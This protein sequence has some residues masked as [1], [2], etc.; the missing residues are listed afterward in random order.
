MNRRRYLA[1]T[2]TLATT[3]LAGCT[4]E[5]EEDTD[6]GSNDGG[7][8]SDGD[9]S[10]SGGD[11]SGGSSDQTTAA[12]QEEDQPPV[13]LVE[14]DTYEEEYSAGVKGV[15]EN[16]TDEELGY[17]EVKVVF[18]DSDGVQLEEG[19]DNATDVAAGRQFRFDCI[20]LGDDF[21]EVADYEITASDSPF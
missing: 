10:D 2:G 15:A 17:A 20:Y 8:G 14:H 7:G 3:A 21:S 5:T 9:D 6:S 19:L 4:G 1:L 16:T 11:D 13:A 12:E 18:L